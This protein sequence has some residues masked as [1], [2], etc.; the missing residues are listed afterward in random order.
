MRLAN[1]G[2]AFEG[3]VEIWH[4]GEW[5]TVCDDD[6]ST[7]DAQVVCREL[8]LPD[9]EVQVADYGQF[10]EG[11]GQIWLDGVSCS[12]SESQLLE[13]ANEGWANNNCGHDEDVGIICVGKYY[14]R[15]FLGQEQGYT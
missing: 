8:G 12:G 15:Q 2:N 6:F 5:G 14:I 10:G 7:V 4:E 13:C 3:R 1:G 11:D 9:T